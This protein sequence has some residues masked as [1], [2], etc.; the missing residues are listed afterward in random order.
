MTPR[1]VLAFRAVYTVLVLNFFIPAISYIVMPQ[2]TYQTI[3][4]VNRL[5][6]GGPY[7]VVESGHLWHMLGTGNVFTL[8]FMCALLLVDLKRFYP[9]LPA[10]MFLK[11]FSAIY[12]LCLGAAHGVPMF[13]AV[14]ALDGLSTLAMWF[15]ATRAHR[16]LYGAAVTAGERSFTAAAAA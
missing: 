3:D 1:I 15:F 12:A 10:L 6:G 9:V 2:T 5:L 13:F 8:A 7:P 4:Q 11:G 16:A 14:F